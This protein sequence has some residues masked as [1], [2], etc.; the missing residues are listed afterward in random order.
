M[1]N[2]KTVEIFTD[3]GC[4]GNPGV[5]GWGVLL[6]Y[7]QN[8]K[9]CYGY[10]AE[11]TNNRMELM[12]AIKGLEALVEPCKVVLTTD[13]QY[14][15]QGITQWMMNWKKRNWQTSKKKPVK[16]KDLWQRLD[17]A[18]VV[19][20]IDWRWVKGHSGHAENERVDALANRA[21]DEK[22]GSA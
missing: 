19:H 8:E 21:M 2:Q 6:R 10:D 7:G 14:V 11:T 13:S 12:A 1:N 3:G 16:N 15:R 4:R 17:K 22:G 18:S 5:G 20:Q 9:E